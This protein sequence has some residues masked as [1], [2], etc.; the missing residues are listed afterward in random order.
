MKW[1]TDGWTWIRSIGRRR[2]LESGR[3]HVAHGDDLRLVGMDAQRIQV[4]LR[5][6][7]AA[8]QS[9]SN[10]SSFDGIER[11]PHLPSHKVA[12]SPGPEW[13]GGNRLRSIPE[14][15]HVSWVDRNTIRL[16]QEPECL[17][18]SSPR[19]P[20][21]QIGYCTLTLTL[22]FRDPARRSR[23]C[24]NTTAAPAVTAAGPR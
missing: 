3:V 8:Y 11:L 16:G 2:S 17:V 23:N 22:R 14:P 18:G 5:D 7:P 10:L 19:I 21:A 12:E 13:S 9:K 24:S 1:I 6:P 4:S 15:G 20:E